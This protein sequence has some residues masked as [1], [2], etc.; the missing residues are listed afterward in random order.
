MIFKRF[1]PA[2]MAAALVFSGIQVPV[3][4]EE[5][6][7]A[8]AEIL[9][10][11]EED[12]QAAE[13][14]AVAAEKNPE[15]KTDTPVIPDE[16]DMSDTD[17]EEGGDELTQM[18]LTGSMPMVKDICP[19]D[20]Q[21][22][23]ELMEAYIGQTLYGGAG[24]RKMLRKALSSPL[25]RL[26]GL[27]AQIYDSLLQRIREV[28]A[29]EETSTV[30]N[31]TLDDLG[32]AG[33]HYT[34][35]DLSVDAVVVRD[36]ETG[37]YTITDEALQAFGLQTQAYDVEK[38]VDALLLTCPYD[39][40][41]FDKSAGYS[42]GGLYYSASF[43]TDSTGEVYD[44]YLYYPEDEGNVLTFMFEVC[45]EYAA[46]EYET[47]PSTG[48]TVHTAAANAAAVVASY[49]NAL[50]HEKL[51]GY[52]QY[53]CR[54]VSY[55]YEAADDSNNI[56]FGNPWQ[57]IWVFDGDPATKVVCEGYAKAF[58]YLC[59][60]TEFD[61]SDISCI[62]VT[63]VMLDD[64]GNA[65]NHM[66]NIVSMNDGKNYL[67]D[68][69]NCDE[70]SVGAD[71]LLFLTGT[72]DGSTEGGY[73]FDLPYGT[74]GYAYDSDTLNSYAAEDLTL[75]SGSYVPVAEP[76]RILSDCESVSTP[77]GTGVTFCVEA[78]SSLGETLSYQWQYQG[79]YG[80]VW[81]N[82]AGGNSAS[83]TKTIQKNWDGWKIRCVVTDESG[84]SAVSGTAFVTV[85]ADPVVITRQPAS[86]S[87]PAKASVTFTLAAESSRG[88]ALS[89]QWQYQG[90]TGTKWTDF[91][92][93]ASPSMTKTVQSSWDG[94]KI[95]C[96]VTDESG[97]SALSSTAVITIEEDPITITVQPA[98]VS[99]P[100]KRSVTFTV[101]ASSGRGEAL[102]YQWQY[103]GT[104]STKWNNFVNAN[105]SSMTK[106]VQSSWNGWKIRCVVSDVSGNS[107]N[108]AGAVI[109]I[110]AEPI[111][112]TTQPAS[113][114]VAAKKNAT[115]TVAAVSGTGEAL[116]YQWQY[117][118]SS[119]TKW[120]NFA[121][122][123][124]PSMTKTVQASWNGWKVRCLVSDASG[125]SAVS[126]SAV[127][128]VAAEPILI[129]SQPASVNTTAGKSVTF[130]VGAA[131]STGEAL[132]YQWQYQGT[133]ST[134]WNNFA[135]ATSSSMTKT[136]QSSWN[137]WK[138]R[139]II[140]DGYGNSATSNAA[141]ITIK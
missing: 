43:G 96:I 22:P 130:T 140:T 12:L 122:A 24:N 118:G 6:A 7:E 94:W 103:Q 100:A 72:E 60:L 46:G 48:Q 105:S 55:N 38:V 128:T 114:T 10:E 64:D 106:T 31:L 134:K 53:I 65:E 37:G 99:V 41:W 29:G 136:V 74:A 79:K 5:A 131:S 126:A 93:A 2:V 11:A 121:N 71:R 137:G 14:E 44:A 141:R 115:F 13:A 27:E 3:Y 19:E 69:T 42:Y 15:N 25:S 111:S 82:F 8:P 107:V 117:Q 20:A 21:D 63:G 80:T 70:G 139:C 68:V 102:S 132:S 75:A 76:I 95:R 91:A 104:S 119:S 123:S 101:G 109:T 124:S 90:K 67:A 81:T 108:S 47:D 56:P 51:E 88:E 113:V 85:E 26:T 52:R 57:L 30:F 58:K 125:N 32:L 4:A 39:L 28:A 135:N 50:D 138:V 73:Y 86:V 78:E 35:E 61:S 23:E 33:R 129:T 17:A 87:A 92:N 59:D 83:L 54:E 49:R 36:S 116:S 127:I 1:M 77:A 110:T 89:Y 62:L 40:Y 18:T 133:S 66:W 98:S 112:I 45:Q 9:E 34:A 84:N 16:E 120:T 97:N